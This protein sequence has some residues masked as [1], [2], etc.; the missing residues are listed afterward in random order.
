VLHV[1]LAGHCIPA[2]C[3]MS[4][5][6]NVDQRQITGASEEDGAYILS[7]ELNGALDMRCGPIRRRRWVSMN[8]VQ[9]FMR[10]R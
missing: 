10:T 3:Q 7:I 4:K 8:L 1:S 5:T 6:V 2:S 9:S